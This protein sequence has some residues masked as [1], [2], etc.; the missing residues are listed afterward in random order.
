MVLESDRS[1]LLNIN[2]LPPQLTRNLT[3][4]PEV[5]VQKCRVR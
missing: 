3:R 1:Y 4:M 5:A 2:R